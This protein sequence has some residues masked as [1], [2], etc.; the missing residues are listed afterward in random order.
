MCLAVTTVHQQHGIHLDFN[1][2]VTISCICMMH[3]DVGDVSMR[4]WLST[5]G[6]VE[7]L[8]KSTL[9]RL[10]DEYWH[11]GQ[12][13][14]VATLQYTPLAIHTPAS[15]SSIA[16]LRHAVFTGIRYQPQTTGVK[17]TTPFPSRVR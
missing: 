10:H 6:T 17:G 14:T 3:W 5:D 9:A 4:S 16:I 12:A 15:F 2:Q 13:E 11:A 8:A 7:N 1:V